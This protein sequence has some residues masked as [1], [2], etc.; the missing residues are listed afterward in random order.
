LRLIMDM[1]HRL[2]TRSKIPFFLRFLV[3]FRIIAF[4]K[5]MNPKRDEV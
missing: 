1:M 3:Y 5:S 4:Y 2:V